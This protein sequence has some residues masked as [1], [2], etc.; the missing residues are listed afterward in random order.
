MLIAAERVAKPISELLISCERDHG[1]TEIILSSITVMELEHGVH[2][3]QNPEQARRRREYL[4]TVFTQY[5]SLKEH[6]NAILF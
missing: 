5:S 6:F 2:R 1:Q 3:A 4:N